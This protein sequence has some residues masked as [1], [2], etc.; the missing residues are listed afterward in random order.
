MAVLEYRLSAQDMLMTHT[1]V[2]VA[3]QG[4]GIAGELAKAALNYAKS[5][6]LRVIPRCPF[7]ASYIEHHPEYADLVAPVPG[8]RS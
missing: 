6:K 7:V 5:H 2:P 4:K 3:Q 1:E 8:E